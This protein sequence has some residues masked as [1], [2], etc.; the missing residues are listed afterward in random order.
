MRAKDSGTTNSTAIVL[1]LILFFTHT[2]LAQ[3]P[4]HNSSDAITLPGKWGIET[5]ATY[6][7]LIAHRVALMPLQ[8]QHLYSAELSLFK[9]T[10]G[11][12]EWERKFLFPEKGIHLAWIQPGSP[13]KLGS[14]FAIYPYLDFP[15]QKKSDCQFWLRYGMGLGYIQHIFDPEINY[16]NSAIGTHVNGVIHI[17]ISFRKNLAEHASLALGA[18]MTHFSNGSLKMPNLGIN[19]PA[20]TIS[21]NHYFGKSE[22]CNSS[23][24]R[25]TTRMGSVGVFVAG[26]IKEIYPALGP[27]YHALTLSS[28]YNFPT[29]HKSDLGIG[30]DVFYDNSLCIKNGRETGDYSK[31]SNYRIGIHGAYQLRVASIGLLFNMG[32]YPYTAYKNDGLF[33]HRIGLRYYFSNLFACINLKTHYARADYIEWGL[34]WNFQRKNIKP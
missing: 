21:I 5:R 8:E 18:G 2:G 9:T 30:A 27:R 24:Y 32:F 15:L 16:T 19:L 25:D 7:F 34:G 31:T 6:G 33:Y 1:I 13:E 26:G 20:A 4:D 11:A 22:K 28:T 10:S 17:G 3:K 12:Q 14:A 29:M 23:P